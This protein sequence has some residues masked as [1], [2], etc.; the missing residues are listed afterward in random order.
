MLAAGVSVLDADRPE[1]HTWSSKAHATADRLRS[2]LL[3]RTSGW[4]FPV[5][6]MACSNLVARALEPGEKA[7][8]G[9]DLL[10][11]NQGHRVHVASEMPKK[12][13]S[14][15]LNDLNRVP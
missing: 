2:G 3:V 9:R 10:Q 5:Y 13:C 11:L 4:N 1:H 15:L 7:A 8:A 6:T 14:V 12:P